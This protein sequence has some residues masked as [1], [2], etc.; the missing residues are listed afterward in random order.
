MMKGIQ[1]GSKVRVKLGLFGVS[2]VY[3]VTERSRGGTGGSLT[4]VDDQ[5]HKRYAGISEVVPA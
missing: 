3:T 2:H 1:A 5:G 4:L